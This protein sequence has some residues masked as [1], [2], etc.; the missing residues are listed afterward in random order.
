MKQ[1]RHYEIQR[2]I[3][4]MEYPPVKVPKKGDNT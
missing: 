2:G 1:K 3:Y 4:G